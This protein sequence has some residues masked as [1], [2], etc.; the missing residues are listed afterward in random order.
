MEANKMNIFSPKIKI[1]TWIKIKACENKH[2]IGRKY[3]VRKIIKLSRWNNL[4][5]IDNYFY[6]KRRQFKV[7]K[8]E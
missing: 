1:G 2:L 4:Y 3:Q 7:L 8:D 6:F 5:W